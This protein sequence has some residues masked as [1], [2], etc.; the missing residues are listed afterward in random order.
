[1]L[2]SLQ[3]I[4]AIGL[5]VAG[6]DSLAAGDAAR[7]AAVFRACVACH[8]IEPGEHLTGPSLADLWNRKAGA[9]PGFRRYSDAL[10]RSGAVWNEQS[11]DRWLASPQAFAPG[12]TM[13]F[14]GIPDRAAREDLIAYL[15]AVSEKKA[16]KP[17]ETGRGMMMRN[18]RADLRRAPSEGRVV[19]IAHCGD[20]YTVGT[21]DGKTQKI[22]E[23]NLRFKTDS[24]RLGPMP[25]KP[26]VVGAGMQG[27]RA[28]VVFAAPE[29][30]SGFVKRSCE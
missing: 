7:G 26:V 15:Q 18:T 22:W 28:S 16:P 2:R 13:T 17:V 19:S 11:L 14:D 20:T 4:P 21:A 9:A 29:E 27:D 23:F 12:T 1:M 8:S 30:I 3:F 25:G 6:G 5:L 24:S 10:K